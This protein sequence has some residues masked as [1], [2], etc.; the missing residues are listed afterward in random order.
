MANRDA[1]L[2]ERTLKDFSLDVM[3]GNGGG[4]TGGTVGSNILFYI[5]QIFEYLN[6]NDEEGK[7][8]LNLNNFI[9]KHYGESAL[10]QESNLILLTMNRADGFTGLGCTMAYRITRTG[11]TEF[12]FVY[13][14]MWGPSY[15]ETIFAVDVETP[16]IQGFLDALTE[17]NKNSIIASIIDGLEQMAGTG[18]NNTPR[19]AIFSNTPLTG[20]VQGTKAFTVNE[21]IVDLFGLVA[22]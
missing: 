16:T 21:V 17:E 12:S 2:I 9:L 4:S 10:S 14:P 5:N 1:K 18:N 19:L 13:D 8:N 22:M 20:N 6:D 15:T 3:G 7:I 11:Q